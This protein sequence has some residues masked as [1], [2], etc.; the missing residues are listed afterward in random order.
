MCEFHQHIGAS[1]PAPWAD[2]KTKIR[3]ESRNGAEQ[4]R[5]SFT[6]RISAD[7]SNGEMDG[8]GIQ[9]SSSGG[10]DDV[11]GGGVGKDKNDTVT[12][13]KD[14]TKKKERQQ[15]IGNLD[16][17]DESDRKMIR[18]IKSKLSLARLSDSADKNDNSNRSGGSGGSREKKTPE[19]RRMSKPMVNHKDVLTND[20]HHD[21]RTDARTERMSQRKSSHPFDLNFI[22][23]PEGGNNGNANTIVMK[24]AMDPSSKRMPQ[25][26]MSTLSHPNIAKG[27]NIGIISPVGEKKKMKECRPSK[28]SGS[29]SLLSEDDFDLELGIVISESLASLHISDGGGEL[30]KQ[31]DPQQ[32]RSLLQKGFQDNTRSTHRS[33]KRE[34]GARSVSSNSFD[35]SMD[36]LHAKLKETDETPD[37]K[38]G[39]PGIRRG[40]SD[41]NLKNLGKG[42]FTP[43]WEAVGSQRISPKLLHVQNDDDNVEL[44]MMPGAIP[45]VMSRG[46]LTPRKSEDATNPSHKKASSQDRCPPNSKEEQCRSMS[47]DCL[48]HS[49]QKMDE[50]EE[51]EYHGDEDFLLYEDRLPRKDGKQSSGE[52]NLF[53]GILGKAECYDDRED[54]PESH[55]DLLERIEPKKESKSEVVAATTST[56]IRTR[57]S[58][59]AK[60]IDIDLLDLVGERQ[61]VNARSQSSLAAERTQLSN[62]TGKKREQNSSSTLRND[63][64]LRQLANSFNDGPI[65]HTNSFDGDEDG[66]DDLMLKADIQSKSEDIFVSLSEEKGR[67]RK[68]V[69]TEDQ[70]KSHE[71]ERRS[72]SG[73]VAL[74]SAAR[75]RKSDVANEIDLAAAFIVKG[76]D[77]EEISKLSQEIELMADFVDTATIESKSIPSSSDDSNSNTNDKGGGEGAKEKQLSKFLPRVSGF[78]ASPKRMGTMSICYC[79]SLILVLIMGL[80][81][82]KK[83]GYKNN[84]KEAPSSSNVYTTSFSPN[85]SNDGMPEISQSH[86]IGESDGTAGNGSSE[87]TKLPTISTPYPSYQTSSRPSEGPSTSTAPTGEPSWQPSY[88]AL[89]RST[90][91]PSAVPSATVHPTRFASHLPSS[92]P[93]SSPGCPEDLLRS[94]TLPDY[95]GLLTLRYEVV[96]YPSDSLGGLLCLSLEYAGEAGWIGIA[97][98]DA[99]RDPL[100]GRK[101]AI[102]G[103]PG[104]QTA[105]SVSTAEGGGIPSLVQQ[106]NDVTVN[107]K[108]RRSPAFVNPG[109]YEIPAGGMDDGY[110]GPSLNMLRVIGQQTLIKTSISIFDPYTAGGIVTTDQRLV[111]RMSFAK[112]LREPGE[113]GIDPFE[114]TLFLYAVSPLS[115]VDS[116][117]DSNPKWKHTYLTFDRKRNRQHQHGSYE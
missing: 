47:W 99:V 93:T 24:D 52:T 78:Y 11:R 50:T 84:K 12:N 73:I 42:D 108:D 91:Q 69:D 31:L 57:K 4:I 25:K 14:V 1:K 72:E 81:L 18:K 85:A 117:Y 36:N 8:I 88:S 86:A 67:T 26:V 109:K 6:K 20:P 96:I 82:G 65:V 87:M 48:R 30:D 34:E 39:A 9:E 55:P 29:S 28:D 97:F 33:T 107:D 5:R 80:E 104:V 114:S 2:I 17:S 22:D 89:P 53:D 94:V 98:S 16:D 115:S 63:E 60:E 102:I 95:D 41:P 90:I 58:N 61:G 111:T 68:G 40:K 83:N 64:A 74:K 13:T 116:E 38:K 35:T 43:H 105:V 100:F 75:S 92:S 56:G 23:S 19:E 27:P 62:N 49:S 77:A 3:S 46:R 45:L 113:I 15:H 70:D 112:Y 76:D 106:N 101:E 79:T 10:G 66:D 21:D 110:H 37:H 54:E 71:Q 51:E 103:F 32:D 44:A 59:H 7:K